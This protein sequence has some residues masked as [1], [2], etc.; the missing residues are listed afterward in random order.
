MNRDVRPIGVCFIAPKAYPLFNRDVE[1]FFGGAEVDLY[2]LANE[3]AKDGNFKVSFIT[4]DY[5]QEETAVIGGVTVIKS[6][7]FKKNPLSGAIRIWQ[8]MRKADADVYMLK[9]AS[10]GVPLVAA[11]CLLHKKVFAYK[12]ASGKECNGRYLKEHFL[13]GRTFVWSLRKAGVVFAQK[14][15]DK[16]NLERTTGISAVVLPNGH[17]LPALSEHERNIILWVGRSDPV[18]RPGLFVELAKKVPD[19]HFVMICQRATGD[20]NYEA[21]V[22]RSNEVKNLEFIER[23]SFHNIKTY[24]QRAKVLV[25]TSSSEGFPNTFIQA[26]KWATTILTLKVNPDG[27]LD[28]YACGICC[29]DDFH[30]LADSLRAMLAGNKYSEYGKNARTYVE[31]NHDI[32]KI[33][34]KYKK[35]FGQLVGNGTICFRKELE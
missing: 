19:E 35:L 6:L 8:A 24:F 4:A 7:D 23:V 27:F 32:T 1:E 33:V 9:T 3:L 14:V 17:L 12:T 5:G 34:E 31:Q 20:K 22:T 10:P 28:E 29:N 26:G 2:L 30:R 13:L 21:L 18:K 11:F 16:E 15:A 25:N